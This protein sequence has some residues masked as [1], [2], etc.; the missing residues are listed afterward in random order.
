MRGYSNIK[1]SMG[2]CVLIFLV[3]CEKPDPVIPNEEELITD[4]RYMLVS[5]D[6]SDTSIL[7]FSD[8]DG[9]GGMDPVITAD[10]ISSAE[11]YTGYISLTNEQNSPATDIGEEVREEGVDHQFFFSSLNS[12]DFTYLDF[13]NNGH[14]IGLLTQVSSQETGEDTLQIVLRHEP[15]KDLPDVISGDITDAGGETDIQVSFPIYVR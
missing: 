3:S 4:L 13:D 6:M 5:A 9:E 14:P 12:M 11:N 1:L 2:F 7:H 10:T 15:Q 8:I